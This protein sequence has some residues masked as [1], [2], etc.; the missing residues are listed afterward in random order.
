MPDY[1]V[2]DILAFH[3]CVKKKKKQEPFIKC[4]KDVSCGTS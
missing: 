2:A 3:H 1:K 4:A